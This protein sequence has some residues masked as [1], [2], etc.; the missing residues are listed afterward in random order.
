M[1]EVYMRRP[2][3]RYDTELWSSWLDIAFLLSRYFRFLL[4][5]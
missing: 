5:D 3:L 4:A 2:G 1:L